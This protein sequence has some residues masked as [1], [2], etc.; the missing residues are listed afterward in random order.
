MLKKCVYLNLNQNLVQTR[1]VKIVTAMKK[2]MNI[3][4]V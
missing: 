3:Y 2:F 4:T 1:F